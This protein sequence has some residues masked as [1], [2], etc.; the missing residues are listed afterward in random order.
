MLQ[1]S[2]LAASTARAAL[3]TLLRRCSAFAGAA[4]ATASVSSS[5]ASGQRSPTL[6]GLNPLD[7]AP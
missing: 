3:R 1:L 2:G 4:Q 6:R 5:E 7:D